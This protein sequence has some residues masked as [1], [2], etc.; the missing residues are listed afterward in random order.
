[1]ITGLNVPLELAVLLCAVFCTAGAWAGRERALRQHRQQRITLADLMQPA[2]L[3]PVIDLATRRNAMREASHAVLHGRIDQRSVLRGNKSPGTREQL[4]DHVASVMRAG[5]RRGDR[6]TH[7]DG[8]NFTIIIPGAD[9]HTGARIANRLRR[10]LAQL[11]F[12][13]F[14][15]D[16]GVTASF[17][18]AAGRYGETGDLLN[19]RARH[20]LGAAL[21]QGQGHV[22][23]A[24]DLEEVIYLPAPDAA[25]LAAAS[26]A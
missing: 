9:E 19:R 4:R 17:G 15:N 1:M 2:M 6:L 16:A 18:V 8:A 26:V 7:L 14:H 10:S 5:L 13:N 22:V 24:S 3:D 25:P 20:A 12:P 23:T 21:C 11:R